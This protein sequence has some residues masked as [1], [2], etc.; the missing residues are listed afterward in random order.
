MSKEKEDDPFKSNLPM[1]RTNFLNRSQFA[2]V[3]IPYEADGFAFARVS[4]S[5]TT[6]ARPFQVLSLPITATRRMIRRIVDVHKLVRCHG[7]I[8][9]TM[10]VKFLDVIAVGKN[11][12]VR[13]FLGLGHELGRRRIGQRSGQCRRQGSQEEQAELH[14]ARFSRIILLLNVITRIE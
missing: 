11:A 8:F 9:G 3:M 2:V 5:T 12:G 1:C 14:R 10:R 13:M 7:T 6:F 4:L